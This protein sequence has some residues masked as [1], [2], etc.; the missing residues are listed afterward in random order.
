MRYSA[1]QFEMRG[2]IFPAGKILAAFVALRMVVSFV[3][4]RLLA[5]PAC[6]PRAQHKLVGMLRRRRFFSLRWP[7]RPE[8]QEDRRFD[9]PKCPRRLILSGF[10]SVAI[11]VA[12]V[13]I[14]PTGQ[15][16]CL[17][18]NQAIE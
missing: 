12:N 17:R 15:D 7:P 13:A 1:V 14:T 11:L 4:S 3:Y 18:D 10:A 2:N 9:R 6:A 16:F 8:L 5:R